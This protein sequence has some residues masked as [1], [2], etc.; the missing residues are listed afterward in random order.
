VPDDER[1]RPTAAG[2]RS[3]LAAL[4]LVLALTGCGSDPAT[5][6]PA[7]AG[8]TAVANQVTLTAANSQWSVRCLR[9]PLGSLV[10]FTVIVVDKYVQHDLEVYGHGH[11]RQTSLQ[12]GPA[13]EH[14]QFR[15]TDRGLYRYRCTVHTAMTGEIYVT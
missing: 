15:F 1:T 14:L 12:F 8:C 10:T 7:P 5:T 11:H 2:W 6:P 13:V 9:V 3:A 4:V